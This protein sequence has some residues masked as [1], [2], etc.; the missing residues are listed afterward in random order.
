MIIG[1][2]RAFMLTFLNPGRAET[3]SLFFDRFTN[4]MLFKCLMSDDLSPQKPF[5]PQATQEPAL[6]APTALLVLIAFMIGVHTYRVYALGLFEVG[7]IRF[8]DVTAFVPARFSIWLG[9][10]SSADVVHDLASAS[11]DMVWLR[12]TLYQAFVAKGEAVPWT[13]ITYA[14][15]HGSWEHVIFNCLWLLAFGTPVIRRFGTMRFML[16]FCV[17][18]A[19]SSAFHAIFNLADVSVLVGAS[20]SVSAL[21]AAALR[22]AMG[23]GFA[24][25]GRS[26]ENWTYPAKPL[27]LAL[28]DSQV[29]IFIAVWFGINLLGGLGVPLG[30]GDGLKIAWEAHVG[31]FFA[32]LLLFSF[33]DPVKLQESAKG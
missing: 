20:G 29:L 22:F 33:F 19:I 7:D 11:P 15:L 17:T 3:L 27:S 5:N 18:A 21:T 10:L 31:G 8:L 13:L 12:R 30:G 2:S 28:R 16:F 25:L 23:Q 9:L 6:L 26:H 14:F 24:G 4:R 32:G 1:L